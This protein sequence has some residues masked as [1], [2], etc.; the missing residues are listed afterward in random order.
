M[1]KLSLLVA[2]AMV[3]M[4]IAPAVSAPLFPD[5]P[6]NVWARDAV[7]ALAAKGI[8]E[9]YPDG[10][11]KGDRAA[12]RYEMAAVAARIVAKMEADAA[13]YATKADLE[14]IRGLVQ[15]LRE[16]LDALGVRVNNLEDNLSKL[17]K[18]VWNLEKIT[19]YG[20]V[21]AIFT[22]QGFQNYGFNNTSSGVPGATSAV[23]QNYDAA[24]GSFGANYNPFMFSFVSPAGAWEQ[25]TLINDPAAGTVNGGATLKFPVINYRNGVALTNGTGWTTLANLGI[26]VR[27]SE[28]VSAGADFTAYV[29]AGD[30]LVDAFWGVPANFLSNPFQSNPGLGGI[31]GHNNQPWTRMNVDN[32]WAMHNASGAKIIA[33]SYKDTKMDRI[34]FGGQLSPNANDPKYLPLFGFNLSFPTNIIVPVKVELFWSKLPDGEMAPILGGNPYYTWTAGANLNF[35][36]TGGNLKLNF[37][38]A[39]N[40][41][42]AGGVLNPGGVYYTVD[43]GLIGVGFP[44]PINPF[45]WIT[46][47]GFTGS[48]TVPGN[49]GVPLNQRP[50]IPINGLTIGDGSYGPIG[51]QGETTWGA[52][53]NYLFNVPYK[54][55]F[56]GEYGNSRYQ[57]NLNSG[58]AVNGNA[59]RAGLSAT[60][61]Q[62]NLDIGVEYVSVDPTYDPFILQYPQILNSGTLG[63]PVNQLGATNYSNV[64]WRIPSFSYIPG[65]YQLHDSEVYPNNRNGYRIKAEY[66]F[67]SKDGKFSARYGHMDQNQ[68]LNPIG[69]TNVL[70]VAP[71]SGLSP[72]TIDPVFT[73][74]YGQGAAGATSLSIPESPKGVV[75]N[76]GAFF[77]YTFPASKLNI[78]LGYE[79]WSFRRT[80][81]LAPG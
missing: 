33:G 12:T 1:R 54:L 28:D 77:N 65:F 76:W 17:D 78:D 51:P 34:V 59:W 63:A 48:A 31:Q 36:F 25:A 39:A 20:S 16:E 66:R 61:A 18:R 6:A 5:V 69:Y 47:Y 67:P 45:Q 30:Q 55:K 72:G 29:S 22:T 56:V 64:A 81:G 9:G 71:L 52:T 37:L 43:R 80:S 57:P 44:N 21:D 2:I 46:P 70:A 23:I 41:S 42:S 68:A 7:A 27:V 35:E 40:D 60:F 62:D 8:V 50:V 79:D 4:W 73:R 58:F 14:T 15:S 74:L 75:E 26:K 49:A 38:R 3:F 32:F 13:N 53:L 24:V 11:Y 10:T 19:F